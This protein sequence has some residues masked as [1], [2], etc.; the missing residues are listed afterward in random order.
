[1]GLASGSR[2]LKPILY[3]GTSASRLTAG[4]YR[5][6]VVLRLRVLRYLLLNAQDATAQKPRAARMQRSSAVR[7][8]SLVLAKRTR[9]L[10]AIG[11]TQRRCSIISVAQCRGRNRRL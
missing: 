11:L 2:S 6:G 8:P 9:R 7:V 4:D 3:C 5:P 1:M 10:A